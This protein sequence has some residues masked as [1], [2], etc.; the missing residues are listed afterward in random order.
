[1]LIEI[2]DSKTID[3]IQERFS[4]CFPFLKIEFYSQPHHWEEPSRARHLIEPTSLIRDIRKE[5]TPG[6][7]EIKSW[8]KTGTVEQLFKKLFGLNAQIFRLEEN[9]WKQSTDSDNISLARQSEIAMK[10]YK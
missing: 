2:D 1:M 5:H 9:K 10:K 3:E 7:L 4:L 8:Y 6:I